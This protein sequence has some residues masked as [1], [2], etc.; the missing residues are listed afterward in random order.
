MYAPENRK[1]PRVMDENDRIETDVDPKVTEVVDPKAR[2][3][4]KAPEW[5][6]R[7]K[8]STTTV[9]QKTGKTDPKGPRRYKRLPLKSEK[10]TKHTVQIKKG[11][12][13]RRSGVSFRSAAEESPNEKGTDANTPGPSKP[14]KHKRQAEKD[15]LEIERARKTKKNRIVE[16]SEDESDK[17][18]ESKWA[19]VGR[20]GET[21][22][23]AVSGANE[24]PG[25]Y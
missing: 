7:H 6:R 1:T 22:K 10:L 14:T 9:Y 5:L 18:E 17:D 20:A 2:E 24:P 19:V 11:S 8:N 16:Y 4:P 25:T 12:L 23:T 21:E 15:Q 3:L 13:L